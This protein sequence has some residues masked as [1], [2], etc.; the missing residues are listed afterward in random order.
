MQAS[1]EFYV[2][3]KLTYYIFIHL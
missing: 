3:L 1:E 2:G